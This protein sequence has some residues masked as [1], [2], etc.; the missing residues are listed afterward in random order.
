[1]QYRPTQEELLL[2]IADFIEQDVRPQ[3]SGDKALSFRCLI[4]ANLARMCVL[5][6]RMEE[7][8]DGLELAALSAL[9]VD[10][11]QGDEVPATKEARTDLLQSLNARLSA[12]IADGSA[13]PTAAAAALRTV[14]KGRL[15][16]TNPRFDTEFGW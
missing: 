4:A 1:M 3:L 15:G 2:A 7:W 14:L 13:D 11:A 12:T 9:G 10:G 16:V 6:R 8:H 5:E